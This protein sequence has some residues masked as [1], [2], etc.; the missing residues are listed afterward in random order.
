MAKERGA[1]VVKQIRANRVS[2]SLHFWIKNGIFGHLTRF[3]STRT[4]IAVFLV[5][6][7]I[8]RECLAPFTGHPF[9]FELWIRL[10]YYTAQGLDPYRITPPVPG[11]SMPG[12][13]D[14]TSLGYPPVWPFIL[15][16]LYRLYAVTGIDNRFFYYFILKQPMII[17][18]LLDSFLIYKIVKQKSEVGAVKALAFWLFC[19]F[20]IIISSVWGMFDQLVLVFALLSLVYLDRTRISASLEAVG[21]LLKAIPLIYLPL[22]AFV[23]KT[24]LKII[25]YLAISSSVSIIFTFLPYL[26]F[27]SWNISSLL[28]TGTSVVTKVGNS[29]NYFV[30]IYVL[31]SLNS[32]PS[33]G[34]EILAPLSYLWIPALI[35][36]SIFSIRIVRRRSENGEQFFKGIVLSMILVTLTFYLTR[37]QINEQYTI[38][39]LGLGLI[40]RYWIGT[41]SRSKQF[42]GI[43]I[44]AL[45]FLLSNN[46]IVRFLEPLSVYYRQLDQFIDSGVPDYFRLTAMVISAF[47]FTVFC[48]LYLRSVYSELRTVTPVQEARIVQ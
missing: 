18:D 22:F 39:F 13:G 15:A 25:Q 29:M 38:Y 44:S 9:D 16:G 28:G 48:I 14:M 6:G 3:S 32:F 26:I 17:G 23:Q 20:T 4:K 2:L 12:S 45:G 27:P 42:H 21:I 24:R 47:S 7:A 35:I 5:V 40:D 37:I 36:A 46:P 19:P 34:A 1:G 10:G 43:W 8:I 33:W 11:L 41:V 31:A 30:V